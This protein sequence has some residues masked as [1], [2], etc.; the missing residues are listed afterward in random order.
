M[1]RNELKPVI[2]DFLKGMMEDW[3]PDMPLFKGIGLAIIEANINK[4]DFLIEMFE[5]EN[6]DINI[7][8]LRRNIPSNEIKIDLKKFS[9]IL[10]NRIIIITPND[11][12]RLFVKLKGLE[13]NP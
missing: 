11:I 8:S 12:D 10:P 13:N 7:D 1:K 9:S 4:Y 6:G 5:D 2:G 3:F